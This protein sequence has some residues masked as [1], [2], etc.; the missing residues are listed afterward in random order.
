MPAPAMDDVY[1]CRLSALSLTHEPW[2]YARDVRASSSQSMALPPELGLGL[3]SSGASSLPPRI[4]IRPATP[5]LC[6][7]RGYSCV[8]DLYID[9]CWQQQQAVMNPNHVLKLSNLYSN[10]G[11]CHARPL[12]LGN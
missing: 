12:G 11:R 10:G 5:A 4:L 2:A 8:V 1:V 6:A 7:A 3:R 9:D